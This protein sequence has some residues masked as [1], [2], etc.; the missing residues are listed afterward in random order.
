MENENNNI[1]FKARKEA[2][3]KNDRLLSREGAA[4]Q[5]G[6]STSTLTN[7]ELGLTKNIPPESIV[8]MANEYHAPHLTY[9]YCSNECPIGRS[10]PIPTN[11]ARLSALTVQTYKLL[12]VDALEAAKAS[13]LDVLVDERVTESNEEAVLGLIKYI[14]SLTKSLGELRLAYHKMFADEGRKVW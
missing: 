14:E 9:H 2:A 13:M 5:L 6:F 3:E 7:Y 11:H 12:C 4:E 10:M 1:Y 8:M